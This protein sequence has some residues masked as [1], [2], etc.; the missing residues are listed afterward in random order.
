MT[1]DEN[2]TLKGEDISPEKD[3]GLF[4]NFILNINS[5]ISFFFKKVFSKK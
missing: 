4:R 2:A 3:G 5:I 1:T